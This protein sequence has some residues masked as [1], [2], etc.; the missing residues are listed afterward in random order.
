MKAMKQD[1]AL[2]VYEHGWLITPR[3]GSQLSHEKVADW[4]IREQLS[5]AGDSVTVERVYEFAR[6]R[7]AD[8]WQILAV[9]GVEVRKRIAISKDL[10]IVPLDDL[11]NSEI[12]ETLIGPPSPFGALEVTCAIIKSHRMKCLFDE[13]EAKLPAPEYDLGDYGMELQNVRRAMSLVR[14]CA[15]ISIASTEVLYSAPGSGKFVVMTGPIQEVAQ[16]T[17]EI[18]TI[19]DDDQIAIIGKFASLP[20]PMRENFKVPLDRMILARRRMSN[21]DQAIELGIALEATLLHDRGV[22]D[23]IS[24]PLRVRGAWLLGED[25]DQRIRIERLLNRVYGHRSAAVHSGKLEGNVDRIQSDIR[26]GLSLCAA[27][28]RRLIELD[29]KVDWSRVV[30]G[31]PPAAH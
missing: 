20:G 22:S 12:K 28:I 3:G 18:V 8:C 11:P 19:E 31:D 2:N 16:A 24:F 30:L 4:M 9:N 1:S 25:V 17:R 7:F 23:P 26:E 14:D 15:P 10:F 5:G 13:A 29:G 21:V 27:V 6:D